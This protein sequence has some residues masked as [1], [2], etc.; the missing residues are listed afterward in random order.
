VKVAAQLMVEHGVTHVVAVGRS[1][2]PSGVISSLDV[3]GICAIP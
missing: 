2:V 1:G 3:V